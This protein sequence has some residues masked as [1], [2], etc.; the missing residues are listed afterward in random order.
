MPSYGRS[1]RH[2]D[3]GV[4]SVPHPVLNSALPAVP[5]RAARRDLLIA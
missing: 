5:E 3:A 1:E 4:A 2:D